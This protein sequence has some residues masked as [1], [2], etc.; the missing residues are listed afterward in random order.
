MADERA[1]SV[2]PIRCVSVHTGA[3]V[4]VSLMRCDVQNTLF[5]CLCSASGY[6]SHAFEVQ[7]L[8]RGCCCVSLAYVSNGLQM[9]S[10]YTLYKIQ[11][12]NEMKIEKLL[13]NFCQ[14]PGH[15]PV[16]F[17]KFLLTLNRNKAMCGLKY[18]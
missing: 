1:P 5:A 11:T 2:M 10:S 6:S 15:Y 12:E 14:E 13:V 18:R 17:Q 3:A 4:D 8:G 16:I 7:I 9:A